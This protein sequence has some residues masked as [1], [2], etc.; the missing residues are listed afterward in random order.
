MNKKR[1]ISILLRIGLAFAFLYAAIAAFMTPTSW[2]GFVPGFIELILP[3]EIFL[4][5][6]SSLEII[7]GAWILSGYKT[8]YASIVASLFLAGIIVP[9]IFSMETI[10]RDVSILFMAIAL[11]VLE[12]K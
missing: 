11:A 1:V 9:N 6:F 10:F 4:S 7:L 12:K 8:Y 3:K 2:V 5:V